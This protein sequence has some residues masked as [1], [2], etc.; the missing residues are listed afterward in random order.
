MINYVRQ[1][2]TAN[3]FGAGLVLDTKWSV[4]C[5]AED[6]AGYSDSD[7]VAWL[8]Y[9]WSISQDPYSP[10]PVIS[11]H[12]HQDAVL[13]PDHVD[14]YIDQELQAGALIGPFMGIPFDTPVGVSPV[15]TRL[16]KNGVNRRIIVDLSFLWGCSVN[17]GIDKDYYFGLPVEVLYPT[18]DTLAY[19]A[20]CV[21]SHGLI[22]KRDLS[23]AFHQ[24]PVDPAD[25]PMLGIFWKDHYYFNTALPMGLTSSTHICQRLTSAVTWKLAQQWHWVMNYIDDFAGCDVP[26]AAEAAS[27]TSHPAK[28]SM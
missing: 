24:I 20:Y 21:G 14:Q 10:P 18:T 7:V 15:N 1:F 6:L 28:S 25:V 5:M 4:H 3:K 19:R 16:K 22:W 11:H 2:G 12:I 27:G 17:A 8:T 13:F 23:R 26:D 9:G